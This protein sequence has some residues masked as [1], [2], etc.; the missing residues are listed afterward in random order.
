[1]IL[2][3]FLASVC[4]AT[5]ALAQDAATTPAPQS[6]L[7]CYDITIGGWRGDGD[8][9]IATAQ[10]L[11]PPRVL[12]DTTRRGTGNTWTTLPAPSVAATMHRHTI[13]WTRSDSLF[14]SWGSGFTG[15]TAQGGV[16]GDSIVG[17][18]HIFTDVIDGRPRPSAP[19][20]AVRKSCDAPVPGHQAVNARIPRGFLLRGGDSLLVD[21]PLDSA[22]KTHLRHVQSIIHTV[23][24]E[25]EAPFSGILSDVLVGNDTIPYISFRFP[26]A[27]ELDSLIPRF[28]GL[29]GEPFSTATGTLA[30]GSE[31]QV[32]G[33]SSGRV[34][35]WLR[36][37]H[38]AG[39]P[40]RQVTGG[41][42]RTQR[43]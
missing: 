8:G 24:G 13:W 19:F 14:L 36:S 20:A 16:R 42:I 11:V 15:V 7:G 33:W 29:Y 38:K 39:E 35:F 34:L 32:Y 25:I 5:A 18:A 6:L 31:A 21:V 23:N 28:I 37:I 27:A 17:T 9:W 4:C 3:C 12:L 43:R 1:M 10:S 2:R 30:D 22:A 26:S 40:V 41:F